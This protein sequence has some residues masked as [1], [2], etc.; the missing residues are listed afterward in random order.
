MDEVPPAEP[1]QAATGHPVGS[2]LYYKADGIF[3]TLEELNSYPHGNGAQVGDIKVLDLND[4]G[5]INGDDRYRTNKSATPEYVFGLTTNFQY[6]GFDFTLFFQGQT[7][8]LSYDNVLTEFG[9][10]DLDNNTVYRATD[11]W[12]ANNQQGTMPRADAWEPG[13]TDFFLYDATFIRLK[14]LELGYSFRNMLAKGK[15]LDDVRLFVSGTN[16]L[17][18]AKEIKWRDPEI[19]G[20][21][22]E[23]PPLRI[24]NF[25]VDVKF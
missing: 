3:H 2:D 8:A 19:R 13:A 16:L 1:Y 18:W 23:Y 17:T 7:G 14:N 22:T 10:Q 5:Q 6:K 21:F 11:R 15:S 20:G 4:D 25:G 12:T 9:Q 24:I